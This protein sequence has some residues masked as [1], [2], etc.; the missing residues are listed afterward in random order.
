MHTWSTV[1]T[2]MKSRSKK[3]EEESNMSA[4][5]NFESHATSPVTYTETPMRR[6][7]SC[8]RLVQ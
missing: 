4:T 8:R 5:E 3:K 6:K 7:V 1:K 2:Q